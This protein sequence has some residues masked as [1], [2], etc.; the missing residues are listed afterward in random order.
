[1]LEK[2]TKTVSYILLVIA[3]FALALM[4]FL[5][6][7]D[8]LLRYLMNSPI[9]GAFELSEYMMAVLVPFAVAVCAQ[10]KAHV[11][12][13]FILMK[14]PKTIQKIADVLT[15][16][17]T[18]LFVI[19]VTY[20]SLISIGEYFESKI[21]SAVLLIPQYPFVAAL[22]LGCGVFAL[23]LIVQFTNLVRKEEAK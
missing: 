15:S 12:V 11:V 17:L 8:V 2:I 22:A 6:A 1:M 19:A 21:T 16:I 9:P 4:M 23:V 5:T 10:E 7:A 14:F 13:D 18:I 20:V 3:S